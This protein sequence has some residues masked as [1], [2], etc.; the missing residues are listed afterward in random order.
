M[1]LDSGSRPEFLFYL[2][3][4]IIQF[5]IIKEQKHAAHHV[6]LFF[7]RIVNGQHQLI[8][9]ARVKPDAGLRRKLLNFVKADAVFMVGDFA[10]E[11]WLVVCFVK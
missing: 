8:V 4:G 9:M 11:N 10:Y 3:H 2:T 1:G 6:L 5:F 7:G